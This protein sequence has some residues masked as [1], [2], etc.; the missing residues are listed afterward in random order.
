MIVVACPGVMDSRGN[1]TRKQS[2]AAIFLMALL[3]FSMVPAVAPIASA[4]GARDASITVTI[5]P[6]GLE[7]NPGES[8]E[9][10]IRV[11]NIGSDPVTV[12]ISSSE[13][14]TAECGQY[15][16]QASQITGPIDAGTYEE[17]TMNVTLTQTAEES[18]ETTVTVSAADGATPPGAPAQETSSVTTTAGDGS[19]SAVFGVDL[20]MDSPSKDWS[21]E[22]VVE[23]DLEVENT[24]QT[25][26]TITLTVN[27]ASGPGCSNA[28]AITITLSDTSV[29]VDANESEFVTVSVEVPEGQEADKYCWNVDGV[30]SN[31]PSQGSTDNQDFDLTVPELHECTMSLSKSSITVSPGAEGTFS[32][33]FTNDG[34]VDWT[35]SVGKF[36]SKAGWVSVDGASSGLLEYDDGAGTKTFDLIVSPDDSI[37]AGSESLVAIQG[38]EGSSVKCTKDIRI[39]SG[40]SHDAS[41]SLSNSLLS[42]IQPDG[43]GTTTLVVTNQG[44]GVDTFRISPSSPPQGWSVQMSKSTIALG[45]KHGNER[46]GDIEVQ[47][48]VPF[49]ALADE[50]VNIILTVQSNNGAVDFAEIT[51]SVTVAAN[52]GMKVDTSSPDQTGRSDTEV[53]FPIT[54]ENSGNVED[55][56]RCA[57]MSQTATPSWG[58]SFEDANG[59]KFT[60]IN[61]A[62]RSTMLVFLVVSIDGEEELDSSRL[63]I[64]VTNKDDTNSQDLDEDG[65]PD[66]QRELVMLAIQS[67]R[68]YQMDVRLD[69]GGLDGR[70][71]MATLAPDGVKEYGVWVKNTGDGKDFAVFEIN[72]L[73]GLATRTLRMNGLVVGDPIQIPIGYGIWNLT[74]GQFVLDESATPITESS[75]NGV[76]SRMLELDLFAGHEARIFEQYFLLTLT[77]NPSA[78]TGDGGLL[79]I[80]VMSESN[81]A[82][83]SG[84]VSISLDVQI[85]YELTFMSEEIGEEITVEYDVSFSEKTQF[86]IELQNTGNI[87]SEIRVFASEN[88]RGWSVSLENSFECNREGGELVCWVDV[89]SSVL[90]EVTVRPPSG[91][92][93]DDTFKFTLSSEPVE[94]GVVDRQNLEFTVNGKQDSGLFGDALGSNTASL[95]ASGLVISLLA[96]YFMRKKP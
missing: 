71:G 7:I 34:N 56:F 32:V 9:Y 80:V 12:Q 88:L 72:G 95:I 52:H 78:E 31:D 92:E 67:D 28:G 75:K 33:I 39:I 66:N 47:V 90:I 41:L 96:A 27:E 74:R 85:I 5:M 16:S 6:N 8:G 36:G 19:G 89:D 83:R 20:K 79:E 23:F 18:C 81:S 46:S 50:Q 1:Q 40:Q 94:T 25:N 77:V 4:D 21:G 53:S 76:E 22:S 58:T 91:A 64:R 35:I 63:T 93:M 68:N 26:E 70:N 10:T 48:N 2:K 62:P 57:V 42:N 14:G 86:E 49:N 59:N 45:S 51:L 13:E 61:I 54:I 73:E 69:D 38:K 3:L 60:E 11:R 29:S 17:T 24:G 15:S 84:T 30:V 87:R 55:T 44:N 43:N 65:V 37:E 82:N